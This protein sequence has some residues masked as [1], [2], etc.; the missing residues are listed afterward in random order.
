[1][2]D[3]R[4]NQ[5]K[6]ETAIKNFHYNRFL[7]LRYILAGFFFSNLYWTLALFM[8]KSIFI[9]IPVILLLLTIPAIFEHARL[10]GDITAEAQNKLRYHFIYQYVQMIF[11]L[12]LLV[13]TITRWGYHNLFPFLTNT[14]TARA[15]IIFI[16]LVGIVMSISCLNRIK[17]I[18]LQKDKHYKYIKELAK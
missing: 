9:L 7:L 15:V 10:Y 2:V 12:V 6:N 4:I 14:S 8:S 11:N 16:L 18:Y 3:K 1:M 17:N 13:L 5:L